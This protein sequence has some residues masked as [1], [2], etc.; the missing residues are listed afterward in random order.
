[1][2]R[3]Y[4]T[5][6]IPGS[7]GV[8]LGSSGS[9]WGTAYVDDV[10]KGG[11]GLG[12]RGVDVFTADG[13]FSKGDYPW[14]RAVRVRVVGGGGGGGGA[15]S[16]SGFGV[17]GCGGGGAYCEAFV[18]VASLAT[19]ETVTVGAGG[20]GG[21]AG[22]NGGS[23]GDPSSF[24]SHAEA[25]GGFAGGGGNNTTGNSFNGG[26]RGGAAVSGDIQTDGQDGSGGAVHSGWPVRQGMGGSSHLGGGAKYPS[27][28]ANGNDGHNYGGGA[29]GGFAN[30]SDT[31]GGDGAD[32][33]VIVELYG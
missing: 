31:A 8:D 32:G 30:S 11:G 6:L 13:T 7:S 10:D 22:N 26:G 28:Q 23:N 17:A 16:G 21:A 15:A 25:G 19:S 3:T 2:S 4:E 29:S 24:G 9:P 5:P 20:A 33:I 12:L 1:M 14:L 18:D 27:F